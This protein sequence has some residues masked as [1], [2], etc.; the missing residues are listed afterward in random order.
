MTIGI[1]SK[2]YPARAKRIRWYEAPECDDSGDDGLKDFCR[3]AVFPAAEGDRLKMG[4]SHPGICIGK[5]PIKAILRIRFPYLYR[6]LVFRF[7]TVQMPA[8]S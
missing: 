5:A 1:L 2:K 7:L 6:S 3:F 4:G 8:L